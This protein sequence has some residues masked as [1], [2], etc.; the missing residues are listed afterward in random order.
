MPGFRLFFYTQ[1]R[2]VIST[3]PSRQVVD[4]LLVFNKSGKSGDQYRSW[5]VIIYLSIPEQDRTRS[6]SI[7]FSPNVFWSLFGLVRFVCF[8]ACWLTWRCWSFL[9]GCWPILYVVCWLLVVAC[10]LLADLAFFS[11]V[12]GTHL[13]SC[14]WVCCF[15]LNNGSVEGILIILLPFG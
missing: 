11:L 1:G 12:G 4:F 2:N 5:R 10:W 9:V 8:R 14:F 3:S 6:L 13:L 7:P 15:S